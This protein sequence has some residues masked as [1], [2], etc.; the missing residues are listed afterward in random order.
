MDNLQRPLV[1]MPMHKA[2][3]MEMESREIEQAQGCVCGEFL[4]LYPP[5]IPMI[6]P[7]EIL[8]KELIGQILSCKKLGLP[9]QGIK[10]Y[11]GRSIRVI[12]QQ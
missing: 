3:D 1:S 4:Y 11:A 9:L 2:C 10:D 7:G 8:T 12:R 6:A 5:G